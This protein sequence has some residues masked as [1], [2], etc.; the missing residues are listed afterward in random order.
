[1]LKMMFFCMFI[2]LEGLGFRVEEFRVEE[3]RVEEVK[4]LR[5]EGRDV[6]LWRPGLKY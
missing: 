6:I 2:D 3:F 5:V 1:M 4:G